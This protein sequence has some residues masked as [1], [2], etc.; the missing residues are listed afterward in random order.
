MFIASIYS[1]AG[2]VN[3][4]GIDDVIL[5]SMSCYSYPFSAACYTY[6]L[7]YVVYGVQGVSVNETI[8]LP[9]EGA[10]NSSVGLR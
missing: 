5:G 7:A 2:D 8:M 1:P 4:D 6:G 3:G 10:F 9:Y